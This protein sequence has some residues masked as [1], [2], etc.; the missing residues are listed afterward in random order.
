[1]AKFQFRLTAL[2]RLRETHRDERRADLA[3]A[4]QAMDIIEQQTAEVATQLQRATEAARA[5]LAPG[6]IH[7]DRI[8]GTNREQLIL[9]SQRRELERQHAL[10]VEEIERRR[11]AVGEADQQV[12][13]LEK[14]KQTQHRR[15]RQEQDRQET[16]MLDEF[17]ARRHTSAEASQWET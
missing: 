10:L 8:M 6:V 12:K 17:A 5:A 1:M 2:L 3:Q 16:K 11:L 4:Y 9:Q 13:V 7:V 15:H 14:L